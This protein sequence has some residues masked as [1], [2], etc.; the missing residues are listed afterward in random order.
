MSKKKKEDISK[1][2]QEDHIDVL[3]QLLSKVQEIEEN[4]TPKS[5]LHE[6][7]NQAFSEYHEKYGVKETS[8]SQQPVDTG[9]KLSWMPDFI[10]TINS[11]MRM[12]SPPSDPTFEL[13]GRNAVDNFQR[14]VNKRMS[15]ELGISE[16]VTMKHDDDE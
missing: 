5:L 7:L 2:V 14:V 16:H 8:N 15:K 6:S 13:I 11:A 9:N 10:S 1:L 4:M 12:V 3:E